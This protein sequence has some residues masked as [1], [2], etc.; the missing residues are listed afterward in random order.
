MYGWYYYITID[1]D[2]VPDSQR[3]KHK[4]GPTDKTIAYNI[5][6]KNQTKIIKSNI[7]VSLLAVDLF[8]RD[9][10]SEPLYKCTIDRLT[11]QSATERLVHLMGSVIDAVKVSGGE[12]FDKLL[13]S[14][15]ECGQERLADE[16][17]DQYMHMYN[18]KYM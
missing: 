2:G 17:Y 5:L 10:I 14:L 7:D 16:L 1:D 8:G 13:Q 15:R 12:Y 9:A 3:H 6:K 4:E 11:G 18:G